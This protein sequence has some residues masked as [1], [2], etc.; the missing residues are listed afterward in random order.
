MRMA[1]YRQS[2][3]APRR[4]SFR[5]LRELGRGFR[6]ILVFGVLPTPNGAWFIRRGRL[7]VDTSDRRGR[8]VRRRI[9]VSSSHNME[10][11]RQI[12]RSGS[13]QTV[14]DIGANYGEVALSSRYPT[15]ASIHLF[16]P[17]PYLRPYLLRSIAAHRD[18]TRVQL[19][20]CVVSDTQGSVKFT[21]DRKWSGTSSAIG[22]M[23]DPDG[24]FKGPGDELF[25]EVELPAL[26]IDSVLDSCRVGN[27]IFKIDVEGY[28]LRVL[29]GMEG[30][31]A[32][33]SCFLGV[34]EVNADRLAAA[35]EPASDLMALLNRLGVV[36]RMG[37]DGR[38]K[39]VERFW[40]PPLGFHGDLLFAS[41]PGL[42]TRLRLSF[43]VRG[44]PGRQATQSVEVVAY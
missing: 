7:F 30:T 11:W 34:M 26:P 8:R 28:E 35:G 14:L 38:P 18:A 3:R 6:N 16:E 40:Q 44:L 37:R 27:L 5:F 32:R 22:Q 21:I 15:G 13:W 9:G 43:L 12:V 24:I 2:A 23:H 4:R 19:H 39:V 33:A 29:R 31:L 42:L 1:A 36:A 10:L 20:Q 25:E 17:N 41:D